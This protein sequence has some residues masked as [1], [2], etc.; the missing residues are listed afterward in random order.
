M[1]LCI[2]A[3]LHSV[4]NRSKNTSYLGTKRSPGNLGDDAHDLGDLVG[5]H[6]AAVG[7][8][9]VAGGEVILEVLHGGER[10]GALNALERLRDLVHVL[11]VRVQMGFLAE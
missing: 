4:C 8:V 5:G 7:D 10:C 2:K 11:N 3:A 6:R 1:P 9:D